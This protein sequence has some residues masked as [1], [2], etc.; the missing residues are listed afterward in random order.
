MNKYNELPQLPKISKNKLIILLNQ[1]AV[2]DIDF[3][4]LFNKPRDLYLFSILLH[5]EITRTKEN[6]NIEINIQD[7]QKKYKYIRG[8]SKYDLIDFLNNINHGIFSYYD[9]DKDKEILFYKIRS[10][11]Y[12]TKSNTFFLNVF[13]LKGL[14]LNSQKIALYIL[15]MGKHAKYLHI[16]HISKLLNIDDKSNKLKHKAVKTAI[17][18]LE[19][20]DFL[21]SCEYDRE[22]KVFNI[23]VGDIKTK[24][25]SQSLDFDPFY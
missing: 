9:L 19:K 4:K 11:I 22:K 8:E 15:S 24:E 10:D 6:K 12:D 1:K 13:L 16:S 25:L 2:R 23:K 17:K 7:V 20:H 21:K 3:L 18:T 5:N 14:K